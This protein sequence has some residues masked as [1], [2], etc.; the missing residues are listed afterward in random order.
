MTGS[1]RIIVTCNK[2]LSPYLEKEVAES[3]LK[4]VRT[5]A[6][7]VETVGTLIDCIKLNLNLRCASQ[8]LF[9]LKEFGAR[10]PED[11]YREV[12]KYRWEDLIDVD[13]Y[14]SVTS[15]IDHFTV[16]NPLFVNVNA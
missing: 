7:G 3:G 1:S 2:R 13:G 6:T 15:H 4:P 11:V 10:S 12:G 5:F 9:S 14:F 16:N 8:V